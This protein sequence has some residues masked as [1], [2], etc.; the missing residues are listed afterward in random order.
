MRTSGILL[1]ILLLLAIP[2]VTIA[3]PGSIDIAG[4]V[5]IFQ[6]VEYPEAAP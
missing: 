6:L 2:H 3:A 1:A 5:A 4:E